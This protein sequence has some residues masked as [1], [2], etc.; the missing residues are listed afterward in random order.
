MPRWVKVFIAI[1]AVLV[2]AL[3]VAELAGVQHGPGLHTPTETPTP[4][5]PPV[6]HGP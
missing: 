4:H 6:D 3:V 1:G 2:V 5:V